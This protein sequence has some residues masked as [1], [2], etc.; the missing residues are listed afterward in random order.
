[1]C[2]LNNFS[3]FCILEFISRRRT[4]THDMYRN[5]RTQTKNKIKSSVFC[6]CIQLKCRFFE[7]P[8]KKNI[9]L[10]IRGSTEGK[11][12]TFGSSLRKVQKRGITFLLN[13]RTINFSSIVAFYLSVKTSP[14]AKL[15]IHMFI[16]MQ[17]KV[18][19]L[20]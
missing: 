19:F 6:S 12:S 1:M 18:V 13:G 14:G 10:Q 7:P 20:R 3:L 15:F 16:F 8:R 4:R 17:I 2:L 11:E 9:S 5:W